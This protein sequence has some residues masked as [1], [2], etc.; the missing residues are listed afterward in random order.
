M[1]SAKDRGSIGSSDDDSGGD[2]D[3][4]SGGDVDRGLL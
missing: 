4:Y 3:V 1:H 2:D